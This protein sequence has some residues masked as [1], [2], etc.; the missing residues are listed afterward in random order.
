MNWILVV[1]DGIRTVYADGIALGDTNQTLFL[2]ED[3]TYTIDLGEPE[4]YS[5][6]EIKK[7]IFGTS[8]ENPEIIRFN[9]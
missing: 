6:S 1:F 8:R 4:N 2:G 9:I 5:P 7:K 3:G